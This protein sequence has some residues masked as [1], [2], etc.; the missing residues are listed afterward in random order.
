MRH[1]R[2][3]RSWTR[4][5]ARAAPHRPTRASSPARSRGAWP[6]T[7]WPWRPPRWAAPRWR[8]CPR[9]TRW[10]ARRPRWRARAPRRAPRRRAARARPLSL[11]ARRC[12][13]S[14]HEHRVINPTLLWAV[15]L[16]SC[17][18]QP[19]HTLGM[20]GCWQRYCMCDSARARALVCAG[21]RT[22]VQARHGAPGGPRVGGALGGPV[23]GPPA[24]RGAQCARGPGARGAARGRRAPAPAALCA[25]LLRGWAC[26]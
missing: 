14:A 24:H 15:C 12:R 6:T 3:S 9:W 11:S 23:A 25:A 22:G 10:L 4:R 16:T 19:G 26:D 7:T 18:A 13:P 1:A 5:R 2:R 8:A 20:F 21:A 17:S